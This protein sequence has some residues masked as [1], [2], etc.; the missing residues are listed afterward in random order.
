M[1]SPINTPAKTQQQ[2]TNG[3]EGATN[4][5]MIQQP[6]ADNLRTKELRSHLR[7][8]IRW[9]FPPPSYLPVINGGWNADGPAFGRWREAGGASC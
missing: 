8:T 2:D 1:N 4:Q 7:I 5:V 6:S 9:G 3:T